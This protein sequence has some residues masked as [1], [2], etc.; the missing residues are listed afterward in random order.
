[1]S[2]DFDIEYR[3]EVFRQA[4][5]N[6][7]DVVSDSTWQ[8]FWLT[9]V[10]DLSIAD[11]AERLGMTAGSVYIARS[12]VLKRLRELVKQYDESDADSLTGAEN[13]ED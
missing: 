6:V 12:R 10:D 2:S 9:S 4:S 5:A 1:M 11:A 3:R 7:R 8:A 13:H